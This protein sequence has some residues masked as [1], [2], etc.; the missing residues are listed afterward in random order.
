MIF[1][2]ISDFYKMGEPETILS[3]VK[4]VILVLSGKGGVGK[5]TVAT[6]LAFAFQQRGKKGTYDTATSVASLFCYSALTTTYLI[7]FSLH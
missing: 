3:G 6:Q 1:F 7:F 4:S 2:S 5:S